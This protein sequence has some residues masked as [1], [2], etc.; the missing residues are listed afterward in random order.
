[1]LGAKSP[2]GSGTITR[3]VPTPRC[4]GRHPPNSPIRQRKTPRRTT[5]RRRKS[6]L[7]DGTNSG[8][9]S[10]RKIGAMN[11]AEHPDDLSPQQLREL[12]AALQAQVQEQGAL[13]ARH[14]TGKPRS[15]KSRTS[16]PSTSA[17]SSASAASNCRRCRRACWMRPSMQTLCRSKPSWTSRSRHPGPFPLMALIFAWLIADLSPQYHRR[18]SVVTNMIRLKISKNLK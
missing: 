13:I 9:G 3:V 15:T 8:V 18:Q 16:W 4:S 10:A 2:T 14:S 12:A 7:L 1:M 5:Q 17:G 6:P 11:H